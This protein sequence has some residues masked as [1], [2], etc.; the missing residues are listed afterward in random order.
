MKTLYVSDLDG[1]LLRSDETISEYTAQTINR[2]TNQGMLFSYATARSYHTA[3]KVTKG[4]EAKIP[5]VVYNGAFILDNV[6]GTVM[7]SNFFGEEAK[8]ILDDFI[9]NNLYP[10]VYAYID[11]V[12][13]FSFIPDKCSMAQAEFLSSRKG[14][15][16]TN[17]VSEKEQLYAGS[18]FYFTC[19]DE[20]EKLEPLYE[21]YK[22]SCHCVFQKDIY[23]GEQWL[24]IMP[25]AASKSNA[26]RQLK[27]Y[28]NCDKVVVF[29]DAIND[30]DMF[31][32]ADECY[33]VAN[34]VPELKA[35]ATQVIDGNNEDG[36]VK[37]LEEE[38][39]LQCRKRNGTN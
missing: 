16:R 19:I 8:G 10:I 9:E 11:D 23:S 25:L 20:K 7:C 39:D 36:V 6:T 27:E 14:D 34:A 29:G 3:K 22:G 33:A 37:W 1:T 17:V 28:L 35:I 5:L 38:Y 12:E 13:K 18:I 30:L 4:L 21:R 2:L 24:E 32:K 15:V 26:I 31:Q